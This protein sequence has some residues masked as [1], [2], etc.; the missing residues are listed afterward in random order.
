MRLDLAELA[1]VVFPS[2]YY[3]LFLRCNLLDHWPGR[4]PSGRG[5]AWPAKKAIASA[6]DLRT[7]LHVYSQALG[8]RAAFRVVLLGRRVQKAFTNRP[9]EWFAWKCL[10]SGG[11]QYA[12]SPH[13]SGANRR[14]NDG[15]NAVRGRG[16]WRDLA[17]RARDSRAPRPTP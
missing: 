10:D 12:V 1:G 17:S 2:E 16:F 6:S 9:L 11:P 4:H 8:E 7:Y 15:L 14:W 3:R 5:D 13:T